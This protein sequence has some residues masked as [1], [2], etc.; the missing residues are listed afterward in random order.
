[1]CLRRFIGVHLVVPHR[2]GSKSFSFILIFVLRF[3]KETF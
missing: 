2:K 3:D 1:M